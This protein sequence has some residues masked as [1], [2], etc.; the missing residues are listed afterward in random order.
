MAA[1]TA[2][3]NCIAPLLLLLPPAC[4]GTESWSRQLAA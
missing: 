1:E 2:A 3:T 4:P